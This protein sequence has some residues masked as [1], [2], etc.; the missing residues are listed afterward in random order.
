MATLNLW[1]VLYVKPFIKHAFF[2]KGLKT[3]DPRNKTWGAGR[4]SLCMRWS[5]PGN[6]N[7]AAS[8][9][10]AGQFWG[11]QNQKPGDG[12]VSRRIS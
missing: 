8:P 2:M 6:W 5:C 10:G 3:Q 4:R 11:A 1:P 7:Q 12:Q 9:W